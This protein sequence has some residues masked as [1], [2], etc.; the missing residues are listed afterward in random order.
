MRRCI[1]PGIVR[2]FARVLSF[3]SIIFGKDLVG[4]S[5]IGWLYEGVIF[6]AMS[7]RVCICVRVCTIMSCHSCHEAPRAMTYA[8]STC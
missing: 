8:K 7:A 2:N 1:I 6:A 3:M 4:P 5:V